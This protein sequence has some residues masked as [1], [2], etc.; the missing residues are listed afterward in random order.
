MG[1]IIEL[2]AADIRAEQFAQNGF[3]ASSAGRLRVS[4]ILSNEESYLML[5]RPVNA[6]GIVRVGRRTPNHTIGHDLE[7]RAET[8]LDDEVHTE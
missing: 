3:Q 8:V 4:R 6:V 5:A 7:A 2:A 1:H